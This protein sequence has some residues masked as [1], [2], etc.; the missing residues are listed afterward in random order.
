MPNLDPQAFSVNSLTSGGVLIVEVAGEVDMTTAPELSRAID[1]VPDGTTH[2]VV[3]LSEVSFLDSS[4]LNT[5]VQGRRMLEE[6]QV[7]MKVVVPEGGAIR[8]VFEITH[9]TEPLT[10]VDTRQSALP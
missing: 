4:G 8:R 6:R 1:Q 5:L 9:L 10:V 3:D 7:A 2:V